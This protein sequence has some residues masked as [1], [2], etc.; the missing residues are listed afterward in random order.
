MAVIE[1]TGKYIHILGVY[2]SPKENVRAGVNALSNILEYTQ[3]HSK[4]IMLA[5]DI[6]ID[7]MKTTLDNT[8][9]EDELHTHN[10]RRLPLPA[11]RITHST[12]TSIDFIC[13]NIIEDNIDT[14]ILETGL[15][16]HTAQII[17]IYDWRVNIPPQIIL[18]R[19]F[20]YSNTD[21]IKSL[22]MNKNWNAV[23]M[24]P[25]AEQAYNIFHR[26]L[27]ATLDIACPTKKCRQK[28]KRKHVYYDNEAK[29]LKND[30]LKA[31]HKFETTGNTLDKE[32]M[33]VKKKNYDK[34]LRD[35]RKNAN[36][37]FIN[38]ADNKSKALWNVINNERRGK[39][40]LQPN[41]CLSVNGKHVDNP[42]Q[43]AD[44]F[45]TFFTEVAELTLK[46]N[47]CS[48]GDA[49]DNENYETPL[50]YVDKSLYLT[51]TC[52]NEVRNI[53]NALKSKSSSGVD[54]Y[55]S[56]IVKH[57]SEE[58]MPPLVSIINKSFSL[59]EFPTALKLS[60]VY[61]KHKKG[62]TLE[63]QNYRPIS[64]ISTFSKI[65]E[66]IALHRLMAH[67]KQENLI[68]EKQ[69]GFLKGKSTSSA[70]ISL[71][72]HVI[73]QIDKE[74]YVSALFLDYSKAF[75]CLGHD[76]ISK[77]LTSLGIRDTANKWFVSYL[78]GRSQ[79]VEL[80]TTIYGVTT[81]HQS[82][83]LPVTRGVP[84]GSVLGPV[85][86]VL[87]VNDFP[88]YI[89]D[90]NTTCVMYADDTT[91]LIKNDSAEGVYES[92]TSSLSKA[93]NYCRR[94]DLA[95]NPSKT[96]HINFSKRKDHIPNPLDV[97]RK[98]HIKFLGVTIDHKLTWTEHVN[99]V[100]KKISTG[101]YVVRRIKCI[102]NL[103]A[104]KT[105]YYSLVETHVRY[106]LAVWGGSSAG[107]L[108]RVLLLQKKAIRTLAELEHQ[109]SCRQA[110]KTLGIM[111]IT[112]LYIQE[113]ILHV[114]QLH[115]QTGKTLHTHNTRHAGNYTLPLHRTSLFEEKPSYIGR[116][117]RNLLPQAV[118]NLKGAAL[119]RCLHNFLV[120]H[121]IYTIEEFTEV[122]KEDWRL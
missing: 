74:Q 57:C 54:E 38:S 111:T 75:D 83:P 51:P 86:F 65:I 6:N 24:A 21:Q 113:V 100:C 91:L 81:S 72:E 82:N 104:A 25:D 16:D 53:I 32:D 11:T 94:N 62:S 39:H 80:Q 12:A 30:F 110:F 20:C 98:D 29:D 33:V 87:F 28:H 5:G 1:S 52:I 15:S 18:K 112:A 49:D 68:T 79:I 60:K 102:G 84:Q 13:T 41:I 27:Q 7:R 44:H 35:I 64:L 108:N 17:K 103:E 122:N 61:P 89:R 106:G 48:P 107:N 120:D 46:Q 105:A 55:S 42:T 43:T 115:V 59:G 96:V 58:L 70:I 77:K 121:P 92:A 93:L 116:K 90:H 78:T 99:Q 63:V 88:A 9:L 36:A 45:N 118:K 14:A 109:Q 8:I 85:L 4:S 50:N 3:A 73:D 22:L 26:T 10:I 101:I 34:K 19:N 114:D 76:I 97:S 40:Q 119:K 56:K 69:H 47:N 66:K 95:M 37:D 23:Y 117:L 2:R 71:V 67:L 31:L